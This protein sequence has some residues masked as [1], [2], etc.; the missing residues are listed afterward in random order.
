VEF[1]LVTPLL[2]IMLFGIISYGYMLSF[3]QAM[4]QSAAEGA[5]AAAVQPL[6]FT[7]S[8]KQ[9]SA[10][11][12]VNESLDAYGV[13]CSGSSLVR[14]GVTVGTCTVSLAACSGNLSKTCASVSLD[15][16]YRDHSLLPQLPGVPPP[17][18]LVYTAVAEVN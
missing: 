7:T 3:R 4:S 17:T 11:N 18:H 15:Y 8:Q 14:A 5:R 16:L 1:A 9:A 10:R 2:L 12:A 13:S 6:S